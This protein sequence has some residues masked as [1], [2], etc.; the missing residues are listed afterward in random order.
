M[1]TATA[2][3]PKR[4]K[5]FKSTYQQIVEVAHERGRLEGYQE[6][7]LIAGIELGIDIAIKKVMLGWP[8]WNDQDI[9]ETFDIPLE[10]VQK[11]REDLKTEQS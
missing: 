4:G 1:D 8:Q 6:G 11:L 9:A 2:L 3:S 7:L 10:R 5:R